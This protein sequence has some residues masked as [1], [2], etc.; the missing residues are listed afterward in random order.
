MRTIT[1]NLMDIYKAIRVEAHYP[2]ALV[3]VN[4]YSLSYG[5][6]AYR[7]GSM[8]LSTL[9][10][11]AIDAAGAGYHVVVADGFGAFQAAL[12]SSNGSP[13]AAG[14]LVEVP[15]VYSSIPGE[16]CNIHPSLMGHQV[17]AAAVLLALSR[18]G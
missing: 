5:S 15:S 16:D 3:A 9:L 14:L 4:Y 7:Q 13:R 10:N 12:A 11:Q 8:A 18:H 17:L 2:H 1:T 6:G